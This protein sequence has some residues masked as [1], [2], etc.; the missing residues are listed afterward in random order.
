M[1]RKVKVRR[2]TTKAEKHPYPSRYGSHITMVNDDMSKELKSNLWVVCEDQDGAYATE[3][4]RL[5]NGLSDSYRFS[6]GSEKRKEI[7]DG[8]RK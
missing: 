3:V 4:S 6:T 1:A 8:L 2:Q 5:D 7:L